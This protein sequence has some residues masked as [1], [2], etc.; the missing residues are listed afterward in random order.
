[1]FSSA[2]PDI[3]VTAGVLRGEKSRFQLFG[4]TVNFASRMES[5]GQPNKIQCSQATADLLIA[6]GKSHWVERREDLVNVK[7]KGVLQTFFLNTRA[8]SAEKEPEEG[9]ITS[10]LKKNSSFIHLKSKFRGPSMHDSFGGQELQLDYLAHNP[11]VSPQKARRALLSQH[12]KPQIWSND[13]HEAEMEED[14]DGFEDTSRQERLV[15][16][17][18]ELLSTLLRQIIAHRQQQ[19]TT[20]V[21]HEGD[22]LR[23]NYKEGQNALDEITEIIEIGAHGSETKDSTLSYLDVDLTSIELSSNVKEQLWVRT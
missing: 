10:P 9:K 3:A 15:E 19:T 22:E 21:A 23:V 6:G 4:D 17:N 8:S 18:V 1:M 2:L 16:W 11:S 14:Y 20:N 13:D 5:T 12:H 7:G